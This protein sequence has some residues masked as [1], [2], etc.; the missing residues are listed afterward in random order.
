M[1]PLH[2][3]YES[4][5]ATFGEVHDW[6]LPLRFAEPAAEVS[7]V[8]KAAG[9]MDLSMTAILEISGEDSRPFLHRMVTNDIL[10]LTPGQGCR[11]AL[12]EHK[13]HLLSD[14]RVLQAEDLLFLL[15]PSITGRIV[16][17]FL[18]R[19]VVADRVEIADITDESA[20]LSVQGPR[21][22]DVFRRFAG[23][24]AQ[25]SAR[26]AH[27]EIIADGEPLRIIHSDHTGE[28]GF[29]VLAKGAFA[30]QVLDR[31]TCAGQ[32]FGLRPIGYEAWNILRI[33]SGIPW[34]GV[35]MD[36]SNLI[37]EVLME[38]AVSYTKGCYI[39]QE[40]VARVR[41]HGHANRLRCGLR[42]DGELLPE[43]E[44]IVFCEGAEAGWIT[45]RAYSP[46]LCGGI[47]M[48]YLRR[49]FFQPGRAVDVRT[50]GSMLTGKVVSLPF[51]P[52]SD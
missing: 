2:S 37:Q 32:E 44:D 12:L 52:A 28:P 50:S 1:L 7:A 38:D 13:G 41:A 9:L 10:R 8:R 14:L 19:H 5:G 46:S 39:G 40:T 21:A 25:D 26:H 34:Y 11:A 23:L 22:V 48:G 36:S 42:M 51:Y 3:A 35:D 45:S 43:A 16:R 31:L 27:L 47:A 17:E 24:S 20:L 18:E 6:L 33:E 49:E 4:L 15:V 30:K 29:D